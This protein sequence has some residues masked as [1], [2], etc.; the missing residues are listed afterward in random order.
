MDILISIHPH[1]ADS[2]LRGDKTVELRRIFKRDNQETDRL[3]IYATKP[4]GA[5]IGIAKIH[6]VHRDNAHNIWERYGQSALISEK[7]FLDYVGD[8]PLI[9]AICLS[10]IET[11][12]HKVTA[13][14]LK[15]NLS[16]LPPQSYRY[17][18]S[19]EAAWIIDASKQDFDRYK[20]SI[21]A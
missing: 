17:L 4:V 5:I 21:S 8:L 9:S 10:E 3:F 2:I 19:D 18:T 12:E 6:S 1:F 14:T 20:Y 15:T 11:F 13:Y 7:Y 16:V